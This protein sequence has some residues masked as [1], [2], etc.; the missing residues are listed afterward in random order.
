MGRE[1]VQRKLEKFFSRKN[2]YNELLWNKRLIAKRES[3]QDLDDVEDDDEDDG[4]HEDDC[5]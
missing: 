1:I 4:E 2:R 3:N 5:P